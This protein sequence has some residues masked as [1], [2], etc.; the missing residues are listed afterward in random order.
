MCSRLVNQ[1]RMPSATFDLRN[2][3]ASLVYVVYGIA[4]NTKMGIYICLV[5][6]STLCNCHTCNLCSVRY[7]CIYLCLRK[8][9]IV[10]GVDVAC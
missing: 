4:F 2:R 7:L 8:F 1:E 5:G 9:C 10:I 3:Y 6:F